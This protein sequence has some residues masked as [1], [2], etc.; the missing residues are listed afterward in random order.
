MKTYR[1]FVKQ[2][3]VH[4]SGKSAISKDRRL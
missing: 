2:E 4:S 3:T 1:L